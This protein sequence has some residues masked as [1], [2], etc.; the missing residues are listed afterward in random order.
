[1]QDIGFVP[2]SLINPSVMV[3]SPGS[4]N[5]SV[6]LNSIRV[7]AGIFRGTDIGGCFTKREL[8]E[9]LVTEGHRFYVDS[10]YVR[11]RKN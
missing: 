11:W 7:D 6:S 1:M 5:N 3:Y 9:K 4:T 2:Q 8:E 10:G